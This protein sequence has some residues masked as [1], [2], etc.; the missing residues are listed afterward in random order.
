[1][2]NGALAL[3]GYISFRNIF[4]FADVGIE[5]QIGNIKI[6]EVILKINTVIDANLIS[7]LDSPPPQ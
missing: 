3:K 1:L 5:N 7:L 6:A 2:I 4:Y